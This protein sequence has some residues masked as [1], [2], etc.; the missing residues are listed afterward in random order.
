MKAFTIHANAITTTV[1]AANEEA[2]ILAYVRDA[3]YASI[4]DAAEVL[5]HTADEFRDSII[6]EG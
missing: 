5:G 3:G 2:A 6:V 1:E 4:E